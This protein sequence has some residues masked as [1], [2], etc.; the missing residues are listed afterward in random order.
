MLIGLVAA[1]DFAMEARGSGRDEVMSRAEAL[2]HGCELVE[3]STW[4][5]VRYEIDIDSEEVSP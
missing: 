4:E 5:E 1:F 2:A 3:S